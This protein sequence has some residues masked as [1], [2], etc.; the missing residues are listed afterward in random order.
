MKK[1]ILTLI[2]LGI[3]LTA[4]AIET[5]LVSVEIKDELIACYQLD[6][7]GDG[8]ADVKYCGEYEFKE[9][10]I[11]FASPLIRYED[12]NNNN[13][14]DDDEAELIKYEERIKI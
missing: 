10:E 14:F 13:Y 11:I 12:K 2:A 8:T 4:N 7:D 6:I 5:R 9:G 1:T 3:G